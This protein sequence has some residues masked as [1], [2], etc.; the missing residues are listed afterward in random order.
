MDGQ[1][2][3]DDL[4][5]PQGQRGASETA[6]Q[7]KPFS[8]EISRD[9]IM[10]EARVHVRK[11]VP[12]ASIGELSQTRQAAKD[13]QLLERMAVADPKA[14]RR[15]G[16]SLDRKPG[17]GVRTGSKVAPLPGE[18][19]TAAASAEDVVG[20]SS[21]GG[22]TVASAA[23]G[24][25]PPRVSILTGREKRKSHDNEPSGNNSVEEKIEKEKEGEEEEG[26]EEEDL[27]AFP[28]DGSP[29]EKITFL[30]VFPLCCAL[31]YSIPN[32][33]REGNEK[34]FLVTFGMSLVWI[35]LFAY[36]MV[37]WATIVGVC[38]NIPMTVMGVTFLAAGTSIPDALSSIYVAKQGFGDMCVRRHA[39][40]PLDPNPRSCAAP[41]FPSL[42][43]SQWSWVEL[44]PR[45][46]WCHRA[47]SSSIGSNVFDI[48]FGL[49]VPWMIK[50][51]VYSPGRSGPAPHAIISSN[52]L[53][54]M[55]VTLIGMVFAVIITISMSDWQLTPRLGY[56]MLALYFVFLAEVL[57]IEYH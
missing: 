45:P 23:G 48:L 3:D 12:T 42:F 54:P 37:W 41:P 53:I 39:A 7:K 33:S 50:T 34:R 46:A 14:A 25:G 19:D 11:S 43:L 32:C 56:I 16:G 30:L 36:G 24:G 2:L 28:S 52:G 44:P 21:A 4:G 5:N 20:G 51:L 6:R 10:A 9:A 26:E 15:S 40:A 55:V 27:L 57:L 47:I 29:R 35:A 8:R 49:P 22:G 13:E 31:T 38:L 17:G 1:I 18:L